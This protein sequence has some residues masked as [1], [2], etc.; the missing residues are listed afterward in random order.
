MKTKNS[1]EKIFMPKLEIIVKNLLD[2][3]LLIDIADL[4]KLRTQP[5]EY[6]VSMSQAIDEEIQ[7][8][9]EKSLFMS[10]TIIF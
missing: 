5:E 9:V 3:A 10:Y 7:L 8:R 2:Q 1:M 6:Y 4:Y